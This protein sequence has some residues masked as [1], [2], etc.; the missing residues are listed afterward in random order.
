[1]QLRLVFLR[2]ASRLTRGVFGTYRLK[3]Q[4]WFVALVADQMARKRLMMLRFNADRRSLFFVLVYFCLLIGQWALEPR[5]LWLR[6]GLFLATCFFSFFGAVITHNTIHAPVFRSKSVNRVFQVILSLTYGSPVSSFVPGHNLSH[7]KFTQTEKDVMRT[8]KVRHDSNLLNMLEFVPRVAIAIL[9][10]DAVY[11]SAM[12]NHHRTWYRQFRL[13]Q[14]VVLGVTALLFL[15][16]WKKAIV[17]WM[18]PHLYAAW[19]IIGMNYLQ[20]DG[21]DAMHT[22]NHSRNFVG[23]WVN[24]WT[25]NNG[26]HGIHHK[27][28][29]LHWSLLPSEH[30]LQIAPFI[31][32]RLDEKSLFTYMVRTFLWPGRRQTFDGRRVALPPLTGDD[33]WVP[34]PEETP[35]DLGAVAAG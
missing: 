27:M 10:N 33:N 21:C 8:T 17:L 29:G 35:E 25:F 9:R 23:R 31:D 11:V 20:H 4:L 13:E 12:K 26:Y 24:W 16:D 3:Y 19:G 5:S 2:T 1:M 22:Y 28:P 34:R 7:H 32:P 30:A 14:A 6:V 18:I 15:L